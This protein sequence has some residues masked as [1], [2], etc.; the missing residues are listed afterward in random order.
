MPLQGPR[1]KKAALFL[2][3]AALVIQALTKAE[4]A[5]RG[6]ESSQTARGSGPDGESIS[7]QAGGERGAVA[8]RVL[9]SAFVGIVLFAC[10]VALAG[11]FAASA[12]D[13]TPPPIAS[14]GTGTDEGTS[15][16]STST[17][18]V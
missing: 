9:A 12:D 14:G 8:P 6:P 16:S 13:A 7:V 2:G 11:A 18:P 5:H 10:G 1:W 3:L 17:D 15:S 4:G